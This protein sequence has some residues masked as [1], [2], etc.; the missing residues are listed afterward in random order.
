MG[1]VTSD[2]IAA[3]V[4]MPN[5][6]WGQSQIL[7]SDGCRSKLKKLSLSSSR[8][9]WDGGLEHLAKM[10][11]L[12]S[13]TLSSVIVP[14]AD[15]DRLKAA[16]PKTTQVTFTAMPAAQVA[17]FEKLEAAARSKQP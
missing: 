13:L 14:Q 9:S 2:A 12:T 16:L 15:I 5:G 11:S 8:V 17:V 10:P 4:R 3:S 7:A 6:P 1:R